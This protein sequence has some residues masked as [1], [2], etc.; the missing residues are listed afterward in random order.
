MYQTVYHMVYYLATH[1]LKTISFCVGC[2]LLDKITSM[3]CCCFHRDAVYFRVFRYSK[4][5]SLI[6]KEPFITKFECHE[7]QEDYFS[8]QGHFVYPRKILYRFQLT[9]IR[10]H[11]SIRMAQSKR[12]NA[13]QS[14]T[15]V[16]T[17][18]ARQNV[19]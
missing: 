2:I 3:Q 14:A 12:P 19:V 16:R 17:P 13:H 5:I 18:L 7:L 15:Y 11:V 8:V 9:E 10:S 1:L 6:W 4:F